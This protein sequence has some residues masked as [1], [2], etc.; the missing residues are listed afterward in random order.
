LYLLQNAGISLSESEWLAI[1]TS[2]GL[3]EESNKLYF[4]TFDPNKEI[5]SN[6]IYIIQWSEEMSSRIEWDVN[7]TDRMSDIL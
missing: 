1:K 2:D 3:Y 5:R 4:K 6:L 7:V